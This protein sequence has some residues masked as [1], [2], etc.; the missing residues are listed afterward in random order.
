MRNYEVKIKSFSELN[1][2]ELYQVLK[3][4]SDVFVV[5]QNCVYSDMDNKDEDSFHCIISF[6]SKI[7]GYAR[8]LPSGLNY[9]YPSIGRV[10][11]HSDF[12][13]EKLGYKLMNSCMDFVIQKFNSQKIVISAQSHLSHF[14]A[15]LGFNIEGE[16]YLEDGIPHVK[17]IFSK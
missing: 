6:N 5:E 15:N 11:I 9:T 3:L 16:Q 7:I 8:I 2:E 14:Y 17:M 10:I 12:R 1:L 4:R 13:G